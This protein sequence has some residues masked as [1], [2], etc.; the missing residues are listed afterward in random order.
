MNARLKSM[1]IFN[2]IRYIRMDRITFTGLLAGLALLIL[3]GGSVLTNEDKQLKD[4]IDITNNT[5]L[6]KI[7]LIK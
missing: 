4:G 6:F 1:R 7:E 2:I 5:E 3:L